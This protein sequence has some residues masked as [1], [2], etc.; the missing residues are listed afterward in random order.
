MDPRPDMQDVARRANVSAQTVS[1]V[2]R[3]HP[4]VSPATRARVLDAVAELGYRRNRA[5]SVLSSGRSQTLGVV[6]WSTVQHS[7]LM[8]A[9][10]MDEAA[11]DAG[12][13]MS[14]VRVASLAPEAVGAALTALLEQA[15]EGIVLV[16]PRHEPAPAV[17]RL[18]A[19]VP[20]VS[21]DGRLAPRPDLVPVDQVE[22][23]RLA[24]QHLLDLGH[25]TVHHVAGAADWNETTSR[26]RGWSEALRAAGREQPEPLPGD[27]TPESGYR[28][29]RV[30][31]RDPDV[32]AVFVASDEMAFG[33]LRALAEAG[34]DVPGDVSVV[35]V[36]DIPLAAYSR[37][38][39]TTVAQP[40]EQAGACLVR[41]LLAS[42]AG[43]PPGDERL[44]PWLVVRDSTAPPRR[45]ERRGE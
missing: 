13:T 11:R 37:P 21:L 39:L 15:V 29:G 23:G 24:T 31:A 2:L 9:H 16:V 8:L 30:L 25:R 35:G 18:L 45:G 42:I 19:Q 3:D 6:M 41:H 10:G 36:D 34:R 32:T 20:T 33:V 14:I 22:I 28:A 44:E 1:R 38:A 40:L 43:T 4:H 5:A 27:W 17:S 12:F 7:E 26:G